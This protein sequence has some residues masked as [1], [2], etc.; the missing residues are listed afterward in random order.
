M[1]LVTMYKKLPFQIVQGSLAIQV[2]MSIYDPISPD[3]E[4]PE[5]NS[6]VGGS[7]LTH[8]LT[9]SPTRG[10]SD[11]EFFILIQAVITEL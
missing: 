4:K 8:A 9:I 1:L 3:I 6:T 2:P 5:K 11:S 10:A 7:K